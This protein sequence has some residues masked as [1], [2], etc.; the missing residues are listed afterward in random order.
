MTRL[1]NIV[2]N[3]WGGGGGAGLEMPEFHTFQLFVTDGRMD[4][5]TDGWSDGSEYKWTNRQSLATYASQLSGNCNIGIEVR[6]A[7]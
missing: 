5:W 3:D 1:D 4:G 7:Q 6:Q 2:A